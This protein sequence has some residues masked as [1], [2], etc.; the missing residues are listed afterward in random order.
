MLTALGQW[1]KLPRGPDAFGER[2]QT[3]VGAK[4]SVGDLGRDRLHRWAYR[5]TYRFDTATLPRPQVGRPVGQ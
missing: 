5:E 1:F 3:D 4:A 2:G